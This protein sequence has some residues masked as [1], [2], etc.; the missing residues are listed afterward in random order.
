[1]RPEIHKQFQD[2]L[3][4]LRRGQNRIT[5][6]KRDP[7]RRSDPALEVIAPHPCHSLFKDRTEARLDLMG[8]PDCLSQIDVITQQN[9]REESG[10]RRYQFLGLAPE[11]RNIIYH[12]CIDYPTCRELFHSYYTQEE[13]RKYDSHDDIKGKR[14]L[15]FKRNNTGLKL[16]TPT[17]FLLCKRIT[18]EALS[19][20]RTR[21]FV[22]D[23]IPPW[24]MGHSVPLPVTS[25]ISVPTLESIRYME[26]RIALGE[27]S[28]SGR[29]WKRVID[30][31]LEVLTKHSLIK[32]KVMFKLKDIRHMPQW[33]GELQAY[34]RLIDRFLRWELLTAKR[35]GLL[36]F[37]YWLIDGFY[38]YKHSEHCRNPAIRRYPDGDVWV[39]SLLQYV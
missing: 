5:Y 38:A 10:S 36:E 3:T 21:T 19:V 24:L 9:H 16:Q 8:L 22:L 20:L 6:W 4:T 33:F 12:Y 34:Q 1:M 17:V 25:F 29:T 31:L 23:N 18:R 32:L 26:I 39:G 37:E 2:W 15:L 35:G 28:G 11:L 13:Q 7:I 30:Q 27:G 14:P